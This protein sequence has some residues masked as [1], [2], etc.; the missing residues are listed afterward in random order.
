MRIEVL[1]PGIRKERGKLPALTILE[2]LR[3]ASL[4]AAGPPIRE[5]LGDAAV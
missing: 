4:P 5:E 1:V 2:P 3:L